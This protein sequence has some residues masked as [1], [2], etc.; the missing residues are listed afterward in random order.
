[1]LPASRPKLIRLAVLQHLFD[2]LP[3]LVDLDRIDAEVAAVVV[4]LVDR[5]LKRVVN[6]AQ[7]VLQNAGEADQNRQIDAAQLQPVDELLQIDG[8]AG[9][10]GRMERMTCP[11]SLIRKIAVAPAGN[12][13]Q[14]PGIG[15]GPPFDLEFKHQ[16]K[17]LQR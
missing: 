6:L 16:R 2:H 14:F 11:S 5:R 7:A 3:L 17:Y 8:R 13:V 9:I 10:F 1:M 12:V 4:V 15:D